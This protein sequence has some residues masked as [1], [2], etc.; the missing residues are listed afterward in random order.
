[1]KPQIAF[2]VILNGRVID[3]VFYSP[4]ANVDADEVKRSLINHDGYH[5]SIDVVRAK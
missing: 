5:P 3:T 2:D 1:M 4:S